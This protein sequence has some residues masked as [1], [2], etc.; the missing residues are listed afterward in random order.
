MLSEQNP[1]DLPI[2]ERLLQSPEIERQPDIH[3][4]IVVPN[5]FQKYL[6]KYN[7]GITVLRPLLYRF[8]LIEGLN[9]M[10]LNIVP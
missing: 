3:V 7:I 4:H 2:I 9:R 8:C 1:Q 6:E 5:E 10:D